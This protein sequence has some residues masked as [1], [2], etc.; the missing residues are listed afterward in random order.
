VVGWQPGWR[1][2]RHAGIA[3]PG[4]RNA[5]R[6]EARST[7]QGTCPRR[8]VIGPR[9]PPRPAAP[10][11]S[12]GGDTAAG[13]SRVSRAGASRSVEL[14]VPCASSGASAA[15]AGRRATGIRGC[16]LL[17]RFSRRRRDTR[18]RRRNQTRRTW[19]RAESRS[20]RRA[21]SWRRAESR[22]RRR[23]RRATGLHLGE[24]PALFRCQELAQLLLHP[25]VDRLHLGSDF[26]KAVGIDARA[27]RIPRRGEVPLSTG[28]GPGQAWVFATLSHETT[29]S[30]P[31][32]M[33]SAGPS[34]LL[35]VDAPD[36]IPITMMRG[37]AAALQIDTPPSDW[38]RAPIRRRVEMVVVGAAG[39]P[40][41]SSKPSSP[42]IGGN[43][44]APASSGCGT[45]QPHEALPG[46]L[47]DQRGIDSSPSVGGGVDDAQRRVRFGSVWVTIRP[48]QD[49]VALSARREILR[50]IDVQPGVLVLVDRIGGV[51]RQRAAVLVG[52]TGDPARPPAPT[53]HDLVRVR[54][55]GAAI[56]GPSGC[57]ARPSHGC[58]CRRCSP[59]HRST[60]GSRCRSSDEP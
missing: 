49:G 2:P 55:L 10:A 44:S 26:V 50:Q 20:R 1:L 27:W 24:R 17:R 29:V 21:P 34:R 47:V 46:E 12:H 13:S 32:E 23:Q 30:F 14:S 28:R 16:S 43:R 45:R 11:G 7:P 59:S 38:P 39:S 25:F 42:T 15:R 40:A 41:C 37:S 53:P 48:N 5:S 58:R 18:R 36:T 8:Q 3:S 56:T 19:R 57:S 4:A 35:V 22:S 33:N 60:C 31:T 52:R 9:R 51:A 6:G 54:R